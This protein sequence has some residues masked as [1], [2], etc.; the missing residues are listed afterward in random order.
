MTGA[1]DAG[2]MPSHFYCPVC[3]K[4]VYVLTHGHHE[5]LRHFQSSRHFAR[6]QWLRLETPGW[7]VLDFHGK[8]LNEDDLERKRVKIKNG[9]LVVRDHEHPFTQDLITDE[10]GVV[11]PQLTVL[12]MVSWLVG[13]LEMGGSQELAEKLWVQFVSTLGPVNIEVAWTRD[14]VLVV[15]VNLRNPF[16]SLPIHI[17]V[18][19]SFTHLNWNA[20]PCSVARDW[21]G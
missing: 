1:S 13:A 20:I 18:L 14:E 10:A 6:D 12:I 7:R 5:V 17:V 4:I 15:F 21:L 19:F 3:Q 2:K 9:R 11:D 16:V 8:P